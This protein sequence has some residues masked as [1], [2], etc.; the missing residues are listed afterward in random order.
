MDTQSWTSSM[1]NNKYSI[2][3]NPSP[4]EDEILDNTSELSTNKD[5]QLKQKKKKKDK[6]KN[7][8]K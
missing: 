4:M 5:Y 2:K 6:R 8:T 3:P 7:S 1:E